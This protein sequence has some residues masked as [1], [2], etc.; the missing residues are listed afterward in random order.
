[1]LRITIT[2]S[3]F[4][5]DKNSLFPFLT[6]IHQ[7]RAESALVLAECVAQCRNVTV[8]TQCA[9]VQVAECAI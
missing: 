9:Q 2:V 5:E 6:R 4:T 7:N 8:R 3:K 1:M